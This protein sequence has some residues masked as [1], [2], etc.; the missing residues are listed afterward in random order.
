MRSSSA[1]AVLADA[2]RSMQTKMREL[3]AA[4]VLPDVAADMDARRR[5]AAVAASKE[6]W[7]ARAG[8]LGSHEDQETER[9]LERARR[10]LYPRRTSDLKR[11][12]ELATHSP[13]GGGMTAHLVTAR[14][15]VTAAQGK[16]SGAMQSGSESSLGLPPRRRSS[17]ARAPPR[18]V[19][20]NGAASGGLRHSFPVTRS[21]T[22]VV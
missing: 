19:V 11:R 12:A 15:G 2:Q 4:G 13:G 10:A 18:V 5:A 1:R 14:T 22:K 6:E 20:G 8:G 21:T 16:S 3:V 7:R 9:V 17:K